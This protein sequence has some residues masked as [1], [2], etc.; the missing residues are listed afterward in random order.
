MAS[1]AEDV[2][3]ESDKEGSVRGSQESH[4]WLLDDVSQS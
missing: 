2:V 1:M 3:S 4:S